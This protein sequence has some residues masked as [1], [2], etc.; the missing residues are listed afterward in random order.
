MA[1]FLELHDLLKNPLFK[2]RIQFALWSVCVDVLA[3]SQET[4]PRKNFAKKKLRGPADSDE[5]LMLGIRVSAADGM[6]ADG[7][8]LTDAQVKTIVAAAFGDLVA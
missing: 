2:H 7:T 3:D 6:N 4:T 5:L 8:A 1:T